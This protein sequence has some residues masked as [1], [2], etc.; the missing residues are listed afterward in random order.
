MYKKI[1]TIRNDKMKSQSGLC[2]YCKQPMW[3]DG[4]KQFVQKFGLSLK[5]AAMFKCTAEH[6]TA[7]CDDGSNSKA[8]LV[9]ACFYCNKTRHFSKK[10][11]SPNEYLKKVR[12]RLK[13]GRW[14]MQPLLK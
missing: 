14:H 2:Y 1:S 6:L 13:A 7:R 11:L 12:K 8:N 5:Q 3:R 10:P 4:I 9:A